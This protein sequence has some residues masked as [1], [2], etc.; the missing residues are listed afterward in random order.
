MERMIDGFSR[1]FLAVSLVWGLATSAKS[2]DIVK[3]TG[4]QFAPSDADFF[5]SSLRLSEQWQGIASSKF[6][7]ELLKVP[8]VK[9][10]IEKF[11]NQWEDRDGEVGRFR[12][13][14]ENPALASLLKL[15]QDMISDEFFIIGDGAWSEFLLEV[16]SFSNDL[17]Q[18][19]ATDGPQAAVDFLLNLPKTEADAIP[20]PG[21]VIGFK[22]SDPNLLMVKLDELEGLL[23]FGL[24]SFP[25][26]QPL[27][28]GLERVQDS[29]GPRLAWTLE[30]DMIPWEMIPRRDE[31]TAALIDHFEELLDGRQIC[32]TIGALKEYLIIGITEDADAIAQLGVEEG[33][34]K[35]PHLKP[36]LD[37]GKEKI[38][39]IGYVSDLMAEAQFES[40]LNNYFSRQLTAQYKLAE[41]QYGAIPTEFESIP[42]DLIWLDEQIAQHVPEQK[43]QTVVAFLTYN[44]Q[45]TWGYSRTKNVLFDSSKPLDILNQLGGDPM[46]LLALRLQDHPEYFATA[47][48][49]VRK[50][51]EYLDVVPEIDVLSEKDREQWTLGLEKGWPILVQL[52]DL[53]E[54]EFMPAMKDGQHAWVLN[55]G[56][57]SSKQWV[58]DMP[59][60][61]SELP[62]PEFALVTGL[63]DREGMSN[64]FKHL[65]EILD[66]VVELARE[67]E[68]DKIPSGY[69]IPRPVRD[70]SVSS[71]ARYTYPI[72]DD[73]P[74]PKT[75]APQAL[76]TDKFL[77]TG[78]SDK[79]VEN[80]TKSKALSVSRGI[81]D[82]K[83]NYSAAAYLDFGRI[84]VFAKPWIVYAIETKVGDLNSVIVPED[85][86]TPELKGTDIVQLWDTF[87]HFGKAMSLSFQEKDGSMVTR[88]VISK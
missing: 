72:P 32:L 1:C 44:G 63:S 57:L 81:I 7:Q 40:Q 28:E 35:H 70:E 41:L 26:A 30:S 67:A 80:L 18:A 16:S 49:I 38:V 33:L 2:V 68:P 83:Q 19:I 6:A 74:V 69:E 60:S 39:S 85:D 55:G 84:S 12:N 48:R 71:N 20:V 59:P 13:N 22:L 52:A 62:L 51:K 46:A 77:I 37:R 24:S 45:E 21:F 4:L 15:G 54:N 47:R 5:G 9:S 78:Y 58:K 66:T 14:L 36:V 50:V 34:A 10:A 31:A 76:F 65:F 23:R 75:M 25:P 29:R 53:W 82:D 88:S 27:L 61:N 11:K 64:A 17:N 3:E 87:Q 43:G 86:K 79:Q 42:D 73:C 8:Y 56:N